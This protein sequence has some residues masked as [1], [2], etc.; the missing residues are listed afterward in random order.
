ME[1]P[2]ERE[3]RACWLLTWVTEQVVLPS[4]K[5]WNTG[6]KVDTSERGR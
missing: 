4:T 6:R 3:G 1:N 5:T 2:G